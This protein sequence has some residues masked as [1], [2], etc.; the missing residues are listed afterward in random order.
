MTWKAGGGG[1]LWL[2]LLLLPLL[3]RAEADVALPPM[4]YAYSSF[5]SADPAAAAE[6]C[7][8]Y[9]GAERLAGETFRAHRRLGAEARV[10]GVRWH[11]NASSTGG[12]D[13][14]SHDV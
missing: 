1:G 7:V 10:E 11:Y 5:A 9:F 13:H 3:R 8:K 4:R 12:D 14:S 2:L 6:F